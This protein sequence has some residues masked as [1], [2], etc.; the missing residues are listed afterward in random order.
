MD[1]QF[2]KSISIVELIGIIRR[3]KWLLVIFLI[4]TL[5]PV[6]IY[7]NKAVPTY[8]ASTKLIFEESE[9]V[10]DI[11]PFGAINQGNFIAN[12][13]EEMKTKSFAQE[14][15]AELPEKAR[16][17]FLLLS[18][19]SPEFNPQGFIVGQIMGNLSFAP[20]R[21]TEVI[22][23]FYDSENPELTKFVANMTAIV[24]IKRNLTIRRQQYSSVKKFIEEQ[25]EIVKHRLQQAEKTLKE[26]KEKENI[27]SVE[28]ESREV[29]QRI[30]QAE[31][32]YNQV[33]TDKKELQERLKAIK[34]KLDTEKKDLT[35][36]ILKTTS[37]LAIKLKERL[38]E[39][40]VM[41]SNLQVQ[42]FP[43]DNP[44]MFDLKKEIER[45]KQNLVDESLKII[46]EENIESL[47]DPFSQ[48]RKF[49]EESISLEVQL[50]AIAAKEKNLKLLLEKYNNMLDN[51]PDKEMKLVR[52]LRD[53]EV[54]NKLYMTLLEEREKARIKEA[55]EI[56]NIRVLELARIPHSPIRPRKLLNI[57]VG[58]FSGLFLGIFMIFVLEYFNDN[59]KTQ[60]DVEKEL[61]LPV[62]AVI[63][64]LKSDFDRLFNF[65]RNGKL[66][67]NDP[68]DSILFDAYNLL[69]F[70]LD[71]KNQKSSTIMVTSSIPSEG[72]STIASMLALTS[73]QRGKRTLLIDADFRRPTLHSRFGVPR[74]PGLTNLVDE[75]IQIANKKE[76]QGNYEFNENLN[77][78]NQAASHIQLINDQMIKTALLERLITTSEKNLFFLPSGFIPANPVRMWSSTIWNKIFP[79]LINIADIIIVDSPPIIGVAETTMMPMY[80]DRI[81]FCI[82]AGGIDRNS[83]KRSFKIFKDII[84]NAEQK[85]IGVVL[86]KAD[87]VSLYGGYKYYYRYYSKKDK[88]RHTPEV[89]ST[90][91]TA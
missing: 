83:L 20:I 55:S 33:R 75:F 86:N 78:L 17:R 84:E 1:N 43:Q 38:V 80:V 67:S 79:Q 30:T 53:K 46:D 24:L 15:Y 6:L 89:P 39:L 13:I 31:I 37:P 65:S 88:F 27:T 74:E 7:N 44:K 11:N 77:S 9:K 28:D 60:E 40:E 73:A 63:P 71:Q 72:K 69:S 14:V 51:L 3:K 2:N 87:L 82:E 61:G 22:R 19:F 29:L 54:N 26:F 68:Q 5:T 10:M 41:Y 57:L 18:S 49:L 64:K 4:G 66:L 48:I 56:G 36:N 50:Q 59:I 35:K 8:R 58:I 42:G 62:I 90:D 32:V 81:L 16:S 70:A 45:I 25:F 52:L 91:F 12:Q 21:G 76:V 23:I 34:S 47:I 85:I